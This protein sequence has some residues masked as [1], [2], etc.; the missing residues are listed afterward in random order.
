MTYITPWNPFLEWEFSRS[1]R[2]PVKWTLYSYQKF[3]QTAAV[4][5]QLTPQFRLLPYAALNVPTVTLI[6]APRV[7]YEW[8]MAKEGEG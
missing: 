3:H 5:A 4:Q 2:H 6:N 1:F 7:Y 8:W